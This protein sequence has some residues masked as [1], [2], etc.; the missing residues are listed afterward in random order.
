[1]TNF[2]GA[3]SNTVHQLF[4]MLNL[5]K[6][7]PLKAEE[8]QQRFAA[9]CRSGCWML[10]IYAFGSLVQ[11][12]I[13][14]GTAST[15][16]SLAL[17]IST[18]VALWSWCWSAI[19]SRMGQMLAATIIIA[20]PLPMIV[21]VTLLADESLYVT[22]HVP[23]CAA[24]PGQGEA[25]NPYVSTMNIKFLCLF[26]L[27]LPADVGL[28]CALTALSLSCIVLFLW[29]SAASKELS[30]LLLF[31]AAAQ[32]NCLRERWR[33][34]NDR[35]DGHSRS[36]SSRLSER[37]QTLQVDLGLLETPVLVATGSEADCLP[38][39]V[40]LW[41]E[42]DEAKELCS[43]R[44]G[45]DV[46]CLDTLRNANVFVKIQR[47]R[48]FDSR[49]ASWT[50]IQFVGGAAAVTTDSHPV[51]VQTTR[52]REFAMDVVRAIDI[53]PGV[54]SLKTLGG[55][56]L[57]VTSVSPCLAPHFEQGVTLDVVHSERYAVLV[58]LPS[59]N[60]CYA[61]VGSANLGL[62]C[63]QTKRNSFYDC[64]MGFQSPLS[65]A[66]SAPPSH[67]DDEAERRSTGS[68]QGSRGLP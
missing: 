22:N 33:L 12:I 21:I 51:P 38:G 50:Q 20:L 32:A 19:L 68:S 52:G 67:F 25:R 24:E 27:G 63:V 40:L 3:L 8:G 9:C 55:G 65:R 61:A 2:F 45:D 30:A 62:R 7:V 41:V 60:S 58:L 5:H 48:M 1:M 4:L 28:C 56:V 34:L 16:A 26:M 59:S 35:R 43:L 37:S 15:V 13:S 36:S 49:L 46:L 42:T 10:P 23:T 54:H 66:Q 47:I 6:P 57:K 44:E 31:Y 53:Q 17:G 14:S 18:V 64:T 29:G 11:L 39:N